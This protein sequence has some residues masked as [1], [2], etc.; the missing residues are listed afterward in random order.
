[1]KDK[2]PTGHSERSEESRLASDKGDVNKETYFCESYRRF[3][4]YTLPRF[5]QIAADISAGSAGE[6]P[7]SKGHAYENH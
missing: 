3:F 7:H 1:M 5:M 4:G 6:K 2:L